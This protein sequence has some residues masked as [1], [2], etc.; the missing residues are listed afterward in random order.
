ML[1]NLILSS[2]VVASVFA[3]N[4][5][6]LFSSKITTPTSFE[7]RLGKLEFPLGVPAH[8]TVET[9]YDHI[10]YIHG[11]NSFLTA[12]SGASTWAARQGFL[13]AGV[14]DN[15]VLIFPNLMDSE[16]LF[17]TGDADAIRFFSFLD[18]PKG[19]VVVEMPQ[20]ILCTVNG[21]WSRWVTDMGISGPDRGVERCIS[22]FSN[23]KMFSKVI[24]YKPYLDKATSLSYVSIAPSNL[25][26]IKLGDLAK[27]KR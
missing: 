14:Q 7:T 2:Y 10:D 17:L 26:L 13:K 24:G 1:H 27:L 6:R 9:L 8:K 16:S 22:L 18:L 15:Y 5:Q 4:N 12:F 19:P 23:H 25:F 11:I 21:M 3:Q 20:D